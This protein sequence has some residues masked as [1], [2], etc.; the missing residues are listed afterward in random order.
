MEEDSLASLNWVKMAHAE[1]G[2]TE[3]DPDPSESAIQ[4]GFQHTENGEQLQSS[5]SITMK[6]FRFG[7]AFVVW[8]CPKFV[9]CIF[10][11]S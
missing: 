1:K 8:V 2:L 7:V 9:K 4:D 10:R 3:H 5:D 11:K 6:F